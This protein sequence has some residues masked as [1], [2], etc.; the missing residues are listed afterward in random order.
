MTREDVALAFAVRQIPQ[1]LRPLFKLT[2]ELGA[3]SVLISDHIGFLVRPN[4]DCLLSATRGGR[5]DESQ[6]LVIPMA[7]GDALIL[8][9]SGLDE[10]ATF[11]ALERCNGLVKA[12]DQAERRKGF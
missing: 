5:E 6:S 12:F 4:P 3:W 9:I 7:I 8:S 2:K 11:K 10:T 1:G